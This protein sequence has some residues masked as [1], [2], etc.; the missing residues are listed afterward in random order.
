[1]N[2][3]SVREWLLSAYPELRKDIEAASSGELYGLVKHAELAG[4]PLPDLTVS[5][6][7][8]PGA[9]RGR[10]L[11]AALRAERAAKAWPPRR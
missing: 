11:R 3:N 9:V 6:S 8:S 2:L 1:M 5:L 10:A 4:A 7:S